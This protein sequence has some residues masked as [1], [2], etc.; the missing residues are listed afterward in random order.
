M[1]PTSPEKETWDSKILSFRESEFRSE[2]GWLLAV[3]D[4]LRNIWNNGD[5]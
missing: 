4:A 3:P 1:L 2:N 5:A